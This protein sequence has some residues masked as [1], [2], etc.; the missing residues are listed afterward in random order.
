M[1]AFLVTGVSGAGKSTVARRLAAAGQWAVSADGDDRLCSW[2]DHSGRPVPRPAHPDTAWLA[3]HEWRWDPDRLDAVLTDAATAG[4]PAAWVCGR[5]D[6]AHQFLDRFDAVFLL[7]LDADTAVARL[8][9]PGRGNDFGQVGDTATTAR[10]GHD[11]FVRR[12]LGYGAVPVDARA[13]LEAVI[14]DLM[15]RAGRL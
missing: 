10:T 8:S 3:G 9:G 2:T 7:D 1:R 6:N 5:A 11:D 13:D 14:Q 12:W 4:V 15:R